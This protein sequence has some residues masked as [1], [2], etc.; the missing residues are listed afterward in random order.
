TADMCASSW[1]S[2]CPV[3][4]FKKMLTILEAAMDSTPWLD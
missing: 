2:G 3:T 1:P 4:N